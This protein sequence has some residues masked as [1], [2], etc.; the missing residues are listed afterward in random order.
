MHQINFETISVKIF[1]MQFYFFLSRGFFNEEEKAAYLRLNDE[2][3]EKLKKMKDPQTWN[4]NFDF[5]LTLMPEA[6]AIINKAKGFVKFKQIASDKEIA[7]YL[8]E[9][10]EFFQEGIRLNSLRTL[11]N[12]EVLFKNGYMLHDVFLGYPAKDLYSFRID[13]LDYVHSAAYF[14]NEAYEYYYNKKKV[15]TYN[16]ISPDEIGRFEFTRI[17]SRDERMLRNFRESYI[18]IILFVESF[19]NSVG[20]D[21]F[22]SGKAKTPSDELKLRGIQGQRQNGKYN[23]STLINK[24]E[25]IPGI[26]GGAAVDVT[27]EPYASYIAQDVE[28]RNGYVHSSPDKPKPK[29]SIEDWKQKCDEMIETKCQLILD[30][31]WKACYPL[32][33]FPGVIF[34]AFHGNSFK[35]IQHKMVV[36]R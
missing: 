9:H 18:N 31:F 11:L 4:G 2:N 33:D 17:Q 14:Y 23:Y 25:N 27:S 10:P 24:L 3:V 28:L 21:A 29:F 15:S 6:E 1:V 26:I 36:Q 30:S 20:Y 7:T 34:N 35:G 22:L 12:I 8:A 32:K 19:I 5:M 13:C 16:D